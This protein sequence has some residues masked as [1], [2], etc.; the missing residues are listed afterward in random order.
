MRK[1]VFVIMEVLQI[2]K[3]FYCLMLIVLV[4]FS[5]SVVFAPKFNLGLS[6]VPTELVIRHLNF[7]FGNEN[8][9]SHRFNEI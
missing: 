4:C 6:E 8:N 2:E 7:E 9:K 1:N 3:K 5:S